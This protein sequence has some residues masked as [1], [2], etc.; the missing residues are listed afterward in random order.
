MLLTR[1]ANDSGQARR[2]SRAL[3]TEA[4]GQLLGALSFGPRSV[5]TAVA[6]GLLIGDS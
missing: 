4:R 1:E 3:V 5:S 6:L 2:K